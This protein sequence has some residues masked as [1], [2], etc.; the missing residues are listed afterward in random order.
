MCR[1]A[2]QS[3]PSAVATFQVFKAIRV[4]FHK[5]ISRSNEHG[6]LHGACCCSSQPCQRH[7]RRPICYVVTCVGARRPGTAWFSMEFKSPHLSDPFKFAP[8]LACSEFHALAHMHVRHVYGK[9]YTVVWGLAHTCLPI[10]TVR[11]GWCASALGSVEPLGAANAAHG[12]KTIQWNMWC[13]AH[14][15][16]KPH[17]A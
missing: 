1:C 17:C 12:R 15:P 11:N 7:C 13:C 9:L 4:C 10:Q 6:C 14:V 5:R 3:F 2:P 16:P 8:S